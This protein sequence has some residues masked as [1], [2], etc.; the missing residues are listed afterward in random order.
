[1]KPSEETRLGKTIVA[2]QEHIRL[3]ICKTGAAAPWHLV[4][5]SSVVRKPKLLER[6][7]PHLEGDDAKK[8][9]ANIADWVEQVQQQDAK[10]A[11]F[12]QQQ[13]SDYSVQ[14][15]HL[16][17]MLLRFDFALRSYEKLAREWV[18][19]TGAEG[20][21]PPPNDTARLNANELTDLLRRIET[22]LET[23]DKARADLVA[24]N[25]ELIV[26]LTQKNASPEEVMPFARLGLAK[27]AENFDVRRGHR[28]TTYAQWWIKTA[29]EEKKTWEK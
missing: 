8:Y 10:C 3:S 28:F 1:M 22:D 15:D 13:R 4:K 18:H 25:E 11:D 19:P 21:T 17:A 14:R 23:I 24:G 6:V 20:E 7:A 9:L 29:I 5:A 26:K 27:A 12:W 2:A 16:I